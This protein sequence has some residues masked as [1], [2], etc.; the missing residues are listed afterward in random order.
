M[1]FKGVD[2]FLTEF[3]VD[4]SL[5][6]EIFGKMQKPSASTTPDHNGN[7]KRSKSMTPKATLV[8]S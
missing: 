2:F 5:L 7:Y 8:S 1:E 4:D 3:R 6:K